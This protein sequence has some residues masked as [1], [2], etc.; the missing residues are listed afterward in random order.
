LIVLLKHDGEYKDCLLGGGF[1]NEWGGGQI[2]GSMLD[3]DALVLVA[4]VLM[5]PTSIDGWWCV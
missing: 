2:V 3:K 1:M 4:D 5:V